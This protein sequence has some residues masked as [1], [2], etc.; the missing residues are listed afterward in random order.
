MF[1]SHEIQHMDIGDNPAIS[2]LLLPSMTEHPDKES[3][4]HI[5]RNTL[6]EKACAL[7]KEQPFFW[8]SNQDSM[9]LGTSWSIPTYLQRICLQQTSE[10]KNSIVR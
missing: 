1:F 3:Y 2:P 8:L 4:H 5:L 6:K 9:A 10:G 7:C